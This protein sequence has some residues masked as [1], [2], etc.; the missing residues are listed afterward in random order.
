MFELVALFPVSRR[1]VL[2][3]LVL[4]LGLLGTATRTT[5]DD[6]LD[7]P[8]RR[9]L[10][11][12]TYWV[13][14]QSEPILER[15]EALPA[16]RLQADEAPDP[17]LPAQGWR[18]RWTGVLEVLYPGEH[19]FGATA[20]GALTVRVGDQT[21]L[22]TPADGG[23]VVGGPIELAF[24]LHEF[25]VDFIPAPGDVE[26]KLDWSSAK[27][28]REPLPPHAVGRTD[29]APATT[30]PFN[31]GW[32]AAEE[33]S[34]VACHAATPDVPLSQHLTRRPGPHLSARSE[35]LRAGW[36]YAWLDDPQAWRPE[37]VM[38]RLFASD[39]RGQV[40]RYAIAQFLGKVDLPVESL[41]AEE[42][43]AA[44]NAGERLFST[45]GCAA[46]HE[47][48]PGQ[49]ARATLRKLTEK[50][51]VNAL[52][53]F[54]KSPAQFDPG[55]RMPSL[56]LTDD[57]AHQLAIYLARR[58][59]TDSNPAS[60]PPAPTADEVAEAYSAL[61][62]A[63]SDR[64]TF[65]QSDVDARLDQLARAVMQARRCASCHEV[66][67]ANESEPWPSPAAVDNF[68]ALVTQADRGCLADDEAR[69]Q[70]APDFGTELP[71][72]PLRAFLAA[73]STSPGTPA[74]A[75][76]A[77]RQLERLNCLAC[78]QRNETGGLHADLLA[79]MLSDQT[80]DNAE[81]IAPPPLTG[82]A[83]KL[84][85]EYLH[86][87][88]VEGQRARP[89][90]AL[91]MP[92]F[93]A[94]QVNQLP[95]GLAALDGDRLIERPELPAIDQQLAAAG[96]ELVGT[97]GFGCIK[98]HDL[99]DIE[100]G[101][102]RGPNLAGVPRRVNYEWYL[103]WMTD[104]Q[105]IQPGTRMP[106]VFLDG[107]SPYP[108]ILAGDPERQRE[109]LWHYF[110][111]SRE[112]PYPEGL[113][114]DAPKFFVPTL[115]PL[116]VRTFLPGTTPRGIAIRYPNRTNVAYDAQ[117]C[118]VVYAWQGDF[119]DMTPVWT[120]RGGRE[121]RLLGDVFWRAPAGFP[122]EVSAADAPPPDFRGRESD[123]QY[124][125][126]HPKDGQHHPSRLRML[127]Y[128][129]GSDAPT[130]QFELRLPDDGRARFTE[131]VRGLR[132]ERASGVW[133]A[134]LAD[135]PN[136]SALWFHAATSEVLPTWQTSGGQAEN[137]PPTGTALPDDALIRV[138]AEGRPQYI[139]P[140]AVSAG[141]TWWAIERDGAWSLLLRL[142]A[143]D[144]SPK[145]QV[146]LTCW[147]PSPD[148][149]DDWESVRS[150]VA[151]SIEHATAQEPADR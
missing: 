116:V 84:T 62:P 122:W 59:S 114:S 43:A 126:A 135:V 150:M 87:V 71:R 39:R 112:L 41:T 97:R 20:S 32:L 99:L 106:T 10:L 147:T 51:T 17:R 45:I 7:D 11:R 104:P 92:H 29:A 108:E 44:A 75:R 115:E 127:E 91:R 144:D 24:G 60:L 1:F 48:Y 22:A 88:L 119:L 26:L 90:M 113:R 63:A 46:C 96:R 132:A 64:A 121:A 109:A 54:V 89:W 30:D 130:F 123:P 8:L 103:R 42:H 68:A 72:E 28:A 85:G 145:P 73:A 50:T 31:Q 66:R 23:E 83:D 57:E 139:Q 47:S 80:S 128:R 149:P 77:A 151:P 111:A 4:W 110:L 70:G 105:R 21:V 93:P 65:D 12:A 9:P 78:H 129:T 19:R 6:D 34:C 40:E 37:A 25:E 101:G 143:V 138:V 141:A 14:G 82:V 55:G 148:G 49:P 16:I 134:V 137:L 133:R 13:D 36:I 35:R 2:R 79:S 18:A 76:S 140:H 100:S 94:A 98:C 69:R 52:A 74:P 125:A 67:D 95:S 81:S 86:G 136:K 61:Q 131:S 5:A 27:F 53:A 33:H 107:Q 58:D 38:P 146:T 142:P 120:E 56:A 124:G 102:T 15:E 117:S 118:R 3:C